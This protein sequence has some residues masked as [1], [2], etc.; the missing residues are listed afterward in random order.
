[1]LGTIVGLSWWGVGAVEMAAAVRGS[2]HV[3]LWDLTRRS[4]RIAMGSPVGKYISSVRLHRAMRRQERVLGRADWIVVTAPHRLN[5]RDVRLLRA[6]TGRLIALLGDDPRGV[7]EVRAEVIARFDKVAIADGAWVASLP[8]GA[9]AVVAPWGS[10]LPDD[11]LAAV[12][13]YQPEVLAVVGSAYAERVALARR[14]SRDFPL[15]TVGSWPS[16][17]NTRQ[18]PAMGRLQTLA[19]L[20]RSRALVV[21]MHHSQFV[22]GFNPQ[23]ADYALA[24]IPQ[25]LVRGGSDA[26][27]LPSSSATPVV[28]EGS[29]FAQHVTQANDELFSV[30]PSRLRFQ[31]TVKELLQE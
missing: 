9:P 21:N 8:R 1:M 22:S 12:V 5:V 13:R 11:Q 16:L 6:Q 4:H 14:L 26:L 2:T 29:P 3:E 28:V 15:L 31:H 19:E 18:L 30:A 27:L 25:V 24:K 20:R 23:F 10:T 17:P 7:R